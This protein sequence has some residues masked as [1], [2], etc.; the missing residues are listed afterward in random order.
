MQQLHLGQARANSQTV[1]ASCWTAQ[2]RSIVSRN[3]ACLYQSMFLPAAVVLLGRSQRWKKFSGPLS[4]DSHLTN[5]RMNSLFSEHMSH[6]DK[7][8]TSGTP[9]SRNRQGL[10][11]PG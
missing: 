3:F 4:F 5:S 2:A 7:P 1:A 11:H 6:A 9:R 10:A 8:R